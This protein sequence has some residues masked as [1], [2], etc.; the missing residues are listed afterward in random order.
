MSHVLQVL[1][2]PVFDTS[3]TGEEV[4]TVNPVNPQAL[5]NND[6]I[7]FSMQQADTL[8]LLSKSFFLI[9]GELDKATTSEAGV[10][11]HG[12]PTRVSLTKAGVLHLF[13]RIELRINNERVEQINEPGL[14]CIPKILST[15]TSDE[16]R[17]LGIMG[18]PDATALTT[19]DGEFNIQIPFSVLFGLGSDFE[20]VLVNAK[21]EILFTRSR[22]NDDALL[23]TQAEAG[24]TL[25]L[26][27]MVYKLPFISV[28][29]QNRLSFLKI[30]EED[31]GLNLI[32]RSWELYQYPE[33]PRATKH[34]WT[35]KSTTQ[36]ERPRYIIFFFQTARAGASL[37]SSSQFD[38]CTLRNIK[39]LLNNEPYPYEDLD[40]DFSK[41]NYTMFYDMYC[42]FM[43]A[44]HSA[45]NVAPILSYAEYITEAPLFIIDCSRQKESLTSGAVDIRL[46]F[47][48]KDIIPNGTSGNCIIIRDNVY[49]Y[50]PL[51]NTIRKNNEN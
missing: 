43:K 12:A 17:Q 13:N 8:T 30:I 46:D 16:V 18:W 45:S 38:H 50:H 40:Q 29:D 39:L 2:S 47:E 20:K 48:T 5:G 28:D 35:V 9:S 42:K 33:L 1:E 11:T 49:E 14:T 34:S 25:K 44:Y 10:V 31:K 36:R 6:V 26:T 4:H 51:T 23:W 24:V 27:K 19:A 37:K 15:M 3:I 22:S 7:H 21:I 41:K 32:Y